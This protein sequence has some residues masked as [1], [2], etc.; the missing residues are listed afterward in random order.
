ML[1]SQKAVCP[2]PRPNG[3]KTP[4][5]PDLGPLSSLIGT[6]KSS[7]GMGWNLIALPF[8]GGPSHYR[9]LL[10]QYD[11]TL[12]FTVAGENV[13]NRA[14]GQDADGKTIET[15]QSLASVGY[16]QDITQ[17]AVADSPSSDLTGG[18]G[19]KIHHEPGMWLWIREPEMKGHSIARL[20]TV[21]HGDS[22]LAL[23]SSEVVSGCSMIPDISG[24][25][26][27]ITDDLETSA[28][29]APYRTFRDRPFKDRF[30]PTNPN[31][32]LRS[33]NED[34]RIVKTTV[35]SVT[36]TAGSSGIVNTP[37][38]TKQADATEM[39]ATLW[40]Q[41]LADKDP[42]GRPKLRIQYSQTV[43]LEFFPRN[44][45]QPGR[46]KWPH[47]SINTLDKVSDA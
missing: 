30:D 6:W 14:I 17:V 45:G 18:P 10:N 29:L 28:Y 21:P 33:A 44:D 15:D 1:E 41:E 8:A 31:Q 47:I 2:P 5:V 22:V 40:I 43:M 16:V 23:G 35:L 12:V 9:L 46:I 39:N 20:A 25:P 26:I 42:S 24:L 3:R 37:L 13:F 4:S 19:L 34:V 27:G 7:G 11:E 32:P 36:S 38:I